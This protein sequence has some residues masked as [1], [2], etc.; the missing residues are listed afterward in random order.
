MNGKDL[1]NRDADINIFQYDYNTLFLDNY[2][3]IYE[4][5]DFDEAYKFE[6]YSSVSSMSVVTAG[7]V[8]IL[9]SINDTLT[10]EQ[11]KEILIKTSHYAEYGGEG[12]EHVVDIGEA[13]KYLQ[14]RYP[15]KT[16]K[17]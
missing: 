7:F 10:P 12:A 3:E 16:A 6:L 15:V 5:A 13:V 14:E 8:A 2:Q 4:R 11:Y 1:Y 9:M 17:T